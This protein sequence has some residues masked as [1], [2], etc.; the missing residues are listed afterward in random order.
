MKLLLRR[1]SK[2]PDAR[3]TL[4]ILFVPNETALVTMELPWIPS[5]N[6][7]DKGGVK[8]K[9][10]VPVGTYRLVPHQSTKHGRTWSLVNHDLDVVHYAGDDHDPDPDRET[11]L[12][13]SANYP[14]QLLGC[15]APGT[16][17]AKAPPEEDCDYM[18]CD[19]KKAMNILHSHLNWPNEH[20][21]E[22]T[23]AT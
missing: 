6:P 18:V 4:G 16:Y 2:Q 19:S 8:G 7:E 21:L 23:E 14:R 22:I 17:T 10:C 11:C 12:L 1:E 13:H 9:S 3:C 20:T 15:I 5:P